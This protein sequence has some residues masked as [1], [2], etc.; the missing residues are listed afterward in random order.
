MTNNN[1]KPMVLI[2][3]D[4][5]GH[6]PHPE[7]DGFNATIQANTP[8]TDALLS[9][10]PWVE[11]NT[12]GRAVGL[13]DGT[14]GNSEV[15]HQN[16][17][18]GRIVDQES[19]RITKA[20]E[21]GP[22]FENASLVGA[23][24]FA[25]DHDR[26]VHLMGLISDA[27]VH[28]LLTHMYA[29]LELCRKL[30]HQKVVIHC[31]M[32]GRDTPPTSGKGYVA[33]VEAEC[34][35][36][37]V[38]RVASICGRFWAMD[39]DN[40]WE[41]VEKAYNMLTGRS[42]F[43]NYPDSA[44]AIQNYYDNPTNDSQN[45]DEFITPRT[46]GSDVAETRIQDGDGVIFFNYRGDRPREISKAFV[47]DQFDG[48]MPESKETGQKGFDRGPKLDL[49]YVTMTGYEEDLN[50]L[51][52]VAYPK[53][54]K[55]KNIAGEWL[56]QKGL[57]SFRCAETEKF[58]HVTFFFNDYREAP[59]DGEDR[60]IVPSPKVSTYD[61]Q[62]EMSA[63]QVCQE[64]LKALDKDY[65]LI[66][67]NF[68]NGDMVGHTGKL[69]A[70]ELA[71]KTVDGCVGRIVDK[72]LAQGGQLL[73]TADHGNS[74]QMWDPE[75]NCPH[76]AHTTYPVD[77]IIVSDRLTGDQKPKL[78]AG[79]C[80]ADVIPTVFQ[81]MGIDKAPEMTGTSLLPEGV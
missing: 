47:F 78:R 21:D 79:G 22:F 37:G 77:L 36:I 29:C 16:I 53:P 75:S 63:E 52:H 81:L 28:S 17:G 54:P 69:E 57:T 18:A 44:S 45:G 19:V 1:R 25:K 50:A 39:R 61:L 9:R 7:Q 30:D 27:G 51:V 10:Y 48:Y 62:P 72:T 73:I 6:N 42:E 65:D 31:F 56:G 66:V 4:G 68:A 70:A 38:G 33:D 74:E 59:F 32:D 55:M 26:Y 40:R 13:P 20:I 49:F 8:R 35:K 23:I 15:G 24:E 12:S 14:M 64:V 76:T 46:V 60:Q 34:A 58:P 5:W 41:R 43:P 67:V 3:R 2:I 80:L 11:V 71:C